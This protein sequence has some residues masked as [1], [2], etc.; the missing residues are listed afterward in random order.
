MF[1]NIVFNILC[2]PLFFIMFNV[3]SQGFRIKLVKHNLSVKLDCIWLFLLL[4]IALF[5]IAM[6]FR[7]LLLV[8]FDLA[9]L[10][11]RPSFGG[12]LRNKGAILQLL[13]FFLLSSFLNPFLIVKSLHQDE[14]GSLLDGC[15]RE[16]LI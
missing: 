14:V 13:G 15:K 12:Y 3:V 16:V 7:L 9:S 10:R 5:I 6:L 11:I 1:L 2:G 4:Q 8:C